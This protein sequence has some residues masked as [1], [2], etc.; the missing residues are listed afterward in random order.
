MRILYLSS[1]YKPAYVYGGPVTAQSSMCEGISK[2]GEEIL[3]LTTNANGKERLD[4]PINIPINV[5]GVNVIYFPRA[6]GG[7]FCFSP[8]QAQ[9]I[10]QQVNNYDLAVIDGLWSHVFLS[11]TGSCIRNRVPFIIETKGQLFPWAISQKKLKKIVYM[12]FVVRQKINRAAA[13]HCTDESEAD[14]VNELDFRSPIFILPNSIS[15]ELYSKLPSRGKFRASL[16][17]TEGAI[18]MIFLGRLN[19]IKRPDIAIDVLG[20]ARMKGLDAHLV[21]AGPDQDHLSTSLLERAAQQSCE[22]RVHFTGLLSQSEIPSLLVDG[23]LFLMPS[24]VNE[25]FGVS[26]LEAIVSGLPILVSTGIPVGRW[27]EEAGVGWRVPC[28]SDD[29]S[30]IAMNLLEYPDQLHETGIRGR[31]L[32]LQHFDQQSIAKKMVQQF[33][34]I[35]ENRRL[36][37]I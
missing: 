8:E 9:A 33:E 10:N 2:L 16:G 18:L 23:D 30:R 20:A 5:D 27:A 12:T 36:K 19:K 4:I 13:I 34:A 6:F 37:K 26:A 14:A 21:V 22:E 15:C 7:N 35:L 24:E 32:A 3:V 25:N 29:F 17:I 1:Y 11:G 28:T 31:E